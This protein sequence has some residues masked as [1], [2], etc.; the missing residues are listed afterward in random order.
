MMAVPFITTVWE[1]F[2]NVLQDNIKITKQNFELHLV[3][4]Y[5]SSNNNKIF[6]YLRSITK[7]KNIPSVMNLASLSAKSNYSK[8]NLFNKYFHS[9]F[10]DPSSIPTIDDLPAIHNSLQSITITVAD[11][12]QALI[13]L[14]VDKATGIDNIYPRVLQSC[15]VALSEPLHQLFTQSLHHS[16]LPT[17]WKIHKIVPIF[18]AGDSNCV[19]N[20][21]NL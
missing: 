4:C 15:A 19:K 14:D 8:V 18:K 9:I 3:N 11:I 17:C 7:S 16:T 10:Y 12:Y 1:Y 5:T 6:K 20:Y 2:E 13:S 21:R